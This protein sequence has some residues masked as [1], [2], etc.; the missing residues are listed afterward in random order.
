MSEI[1]YQNFRCYILQQGDQNPPANSS[2][3]GWVRKILM[4]EGDQADSWHMCSN[5][6]VF[7]V[8]KTVQKTQVN[9]YHSYLQYSSNEQ[10]F[11]SVFSFRQPKVGWKT[12]WEVGEV[13]ERTKDLINFITFLQC[14]KPT[15]E[16]CSLALPLSDD[17]W[18][19][20]SNNAGDIDSAGVGL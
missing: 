1:H 11:G 12:L 17:P 10:F 19:F 4:F 16:S 9:L 6:R 20:I 14:L 5:W 3:G 8:C 7:L 15:F 13:L 18:I 2:R